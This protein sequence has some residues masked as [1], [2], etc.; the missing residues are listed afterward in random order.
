[1]KKFFEKNNKNVKNDNNENNMANKNES[2]KNIKNI[3]GKINKKKLIA[4]LILVI[5]TV[6][7][8]LI[9]FKLSIFNNANITNT[10]TNKNNISGQNNID[11]NYDKKI[12]EIGD[13]V[14]NI[15]AERL[16]ELKDGLNEQIGSL[17]DNILILKKENETLKEKIENLNLEI[18]QIKSQKPENNLNNLKLLITL[19]KVKNNFDSSV[20][21]S[22]DL[23]LL[24]IFSKNSSTSL[25]EMVIELEYTLEKAK[26]INITN[27]FLKEVE[28]AIS[29]KQEKTDNKLLSIFY[30]NFSIRKVGNFS[31]D[32]EKSLDY[33]IYEI[34]QNLETKEYKNAVENIEKYNLTDEFKETLNSLNLLLKVNEIFNK[35]VDIVYLGYLQ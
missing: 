9:S 15:V 2:K 26:S 11:D 16:T 5:L 18:T 4:V 30:K 10:S 34:Q 23:K 33:K 19:I 20:D 27:I 22:E 3:L 29:Q 7:T 25:N 13:L 8:I 24:K 21:Y 17:A 14:V 6:I 12:E 35:I 1:M 31:K 32:D 28:K